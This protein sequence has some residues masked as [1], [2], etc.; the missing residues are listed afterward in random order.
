MDDRWFAIKLM[1][2]ENLAVLLKTGTVRSAAENITFGSMSSLAELDISNVI[3]FAGRI[4]L[5][6]P[7]EFALRLG[8]GHEERGSV[9]M[10]LEG[11]TWKLSG[12]GLPA[13]A[14]PTWW[15]GCRRGDPLRS[16]PTALR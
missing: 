2:P 11:T 8:D 6:K 5:I 3:V 16:P 4:T 9:S 12:I 15:T 14:S 13:R 1:T 10:H 7:V